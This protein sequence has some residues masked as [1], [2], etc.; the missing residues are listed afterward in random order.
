MCQHI[1]SLRYRTHW[2]MMEGI[3]KLILKSNRSRDYTD[4]TYLI[5]AKMGA[6]ENVTDYVARLLPI[7]DRLELSQK[8]RR[9][10]SREVEEYLHADWPSS[11]IRVN[12]DLLTTVETNISFPDLVEMLKRKEQSVES[13]KIAKQFQGTPLI[14]GANVHTTRETFKG[15]KN[16]SKGRQRSR[17]PS[18]SKSNSRSTGKSNLT[19]YYCGHKGHI[20]SECRT[21]QRATNAKPK[22]QSRDHQANVHASLG[23]EV[24]CMR[25]LSADRRSSKNLPGVT[26]VTQG[27]RGTLLCCFNL[28]YFLK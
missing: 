11:F 9:T 14:A 18:N 26:L 21:K 25:S 5:S 22:V 1:L 16:Y 4:L 24:L 12:V 8:F 2:E 13:T 10:F 23:T 15:G 27:K 19:C 3:D 6:D 20:K 17:N 7:F 28:Y